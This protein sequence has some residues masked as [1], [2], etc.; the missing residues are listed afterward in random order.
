LKKRGLTNAVVCNKGGKEFIRGKK[1]FEEVGFKYDYL[2]K[3]FSTPNNYGRVQKWKVRIIKTGEPYGRGGSLKNEGKPL[4]EFISKDK[5]QFVSRYYLETLLER[6]PNVIYG[7]NLQG[8]VP[9]WSIDSAGYKK[10]D[11]W[12]RGLK[13]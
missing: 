5:N 2:E 1:V 12:L 6:D 3:V 13:L 9:A 4:V 8:D 7:L 11:K 10:I